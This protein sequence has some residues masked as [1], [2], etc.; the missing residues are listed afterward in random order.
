MSGVISVTPDLM[1]F[2]V[3]CLKNAANTMKAS[4]TDVSS[5]TS[6]AQTLK[7]YEETLHNI[8]FLI[9]QYKM[10]VEKDCISLFTVLDN[11]VGV[12][13]RFA[14][15]FGL[16]SYS[17]FAIHNYGIGADGLSAKQFKPQP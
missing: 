13:E 17:Q 10:L 6:N 3:L 9:G 16:Q 1:Y 8:G 7:R 4:T 11:M 12:D 5:I 2:A 14:K 15:Q